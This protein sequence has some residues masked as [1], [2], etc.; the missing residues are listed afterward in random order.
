MRQRGGKAIGRVGVYKV[1][2]DRGDAEL[3]VRPDY[4]SGDV[5]FV[6]GEA[7]TVEGER[8]LVEWLLPGDP[9]VARMRPVI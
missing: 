7:Y 1:E 3:D 2:I 4:D 5:P 6:R 8:L 9:P